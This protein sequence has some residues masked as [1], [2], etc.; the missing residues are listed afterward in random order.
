M[1]NVVEAFFLDR[2]LETLHWEPQMHTFIKQEALTFFN[3]WV[4]ANTWENVKNYDILATLEAL[5]NEDTLLRTHCC[6]HKCFPVCPRA[7][8]LLRT[9]I[10]C[11]GLKKCFWFCS[12]TICVRNKCFPVCAAQ[13]TSWATMCPRLP[14]PLVW[15]AGLTVEL[16]RRFQ[17]TPANFERGRSVDI[18]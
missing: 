9:Q 6:R 10:L 1:N 4:I 2:R 15:T 12:E 14:G 7:Q 3:G 17:I 16:K 5:E 11:P 13:E 18:A 8:H